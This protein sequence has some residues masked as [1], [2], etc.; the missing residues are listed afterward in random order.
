MTVTSPDQTACRQT[1]KPVLP[2]LHRLFQGS[3]SS[4]FTDGQLLDRYVQAR[5][6]DAFALLVHRH[7]PMVLGVCKRVV[8]HGHNA[9]DAFQAT[10][11]ILV[12]RAESIQPREM[13]GHWLYGVAYRTA[14]SARHAAF[15]RWSREKSL[16][17]MALADQNSGPASTDWLPL[18][19]REIHRL[20]EI[21]RR[22]VVLCELQGKS[23]REAARLLGLSEGTLSSRL[24][25]AR[26]QLALRLKSRGLLGLAAFGSPLLSGSQ[27]AVP[28]VLEQSTL[29]WAQTLIASS[30]VATVLPTAIVTLIQGATR[31]MFLT[32]TKILALTSLLLCGSGG[33]FWW[34]N[35]ATAEQPHGAVAAVQPDLLVVPPQ[36]ADAQPSTIAPLAD[37]TSLDDDKDHKKHADHKHDQHQHRETITGSGNIKK[38]N[39]DVKGFSAIRFDSA[40]KVTIRRTGKEKLSLQADDNILP[41]LKTDVQEETLVIRAAKDV[42]L[43]P[44]KQAEYVIEVSDFNKLEL[45]GAGTINVEKVQADQF[46]LNILGAGTLTLDGEAK[47]LN[48]TLLGAGTVAADQLQVQTAKISLPGSGTIHVNARESLDV[49]I[50]G[51]GSIRYLG[52][53]K[54]TK[55]IRGVG[56]IKKADSS[57]KKNRDGDE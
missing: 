12:R 26:K 39:R 14:L 18:L 35:A 21:Y 43:K 57:S 27:A 33:S 34:L 16:G 37:N 41:L 36:S 54:I 5:D 38:E 51:A 8:G 45:R 31:S 24:A 20:P 7:G 23:R 25:K 6:S 13:V 46:T 32:K 50:N 2:A 9:E 1:S 10:F 19:D 11:L 42:N 4:G 47:N 17:E 48:V 3:A 30:G 22:P 15:R 53:P 49:T 29:H 44:S 52:D 55:S 56:S 28:C 40:G